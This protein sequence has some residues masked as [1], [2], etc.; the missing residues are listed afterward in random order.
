MSVSQGA[1]GDAEAQGRLQGGWGLMAL[2]ASLLAVPN[3]GGRRLQEQR[4]QQ[5]GSCLQS[6][7]LIALHHTYV[8]CTIIAG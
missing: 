7:F 1:L 4:A 5:A 6:F 2:G 8:N 3:P